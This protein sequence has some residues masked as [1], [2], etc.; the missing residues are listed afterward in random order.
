[1]KADR[2]VPN[3]LIRMAEDHQRLGEECPFIMALIAFEH[4]QLNKIPPDILK[5]LIT[6]YQKREATSWICGG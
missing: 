2:M 6:T 5:R 4:G 1:M 3:N